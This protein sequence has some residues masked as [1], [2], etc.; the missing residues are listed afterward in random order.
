MSRCV[1]ECR[2]ASWGLRRSTLAD[3]ASKSKM[4]AFS[5]G[6]ILV[7]TLRNRSLDSTARMTGGPSRRKSEKRDLDVSAW[8][9]LTLGSD[10]QRS[11]RSHR[12]HC[13]EMPLQSPPGGLH[14]PS[15][16]FAAQVG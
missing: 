8:V 13:S 12:V 11:S 7:S 16:T 5:R 3:D 9:L 1:S 10:S 6:P 2:H 14:I 4:Y 15:K